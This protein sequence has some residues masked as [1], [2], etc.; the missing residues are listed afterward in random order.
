MDYLHNDEVLSNEVQLISTP[1]CT[2]AERHLNLGAHLISTEAETA[3]PSSHDHGLF[4]NAAPTRLDFSNR[5]K[6]V[7]R[8]S[9]CK[10]EWEGG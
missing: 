2:P 10:R 1:I 3:C 7:V 9:N 4:G 6:A 8:K 5:H